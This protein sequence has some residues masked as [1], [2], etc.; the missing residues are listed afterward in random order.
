MIIQRNPRP[1]AT[2]RGSVTL[3]LAVLAPMLLILLGLIVAAGRIELAG[4]SVETA[5]ADA[6]R[7]ASIA[8]TPAAA[9]AAAEGSARATLAAEGLSCSQLSVAVDTAGFAAPLGQ[10]AAVSAHVSCTVTLADLLVPGMPGSHR[11]D[12]TSTSPLDPYRGRAL[13][14]GNSEALFGLNSSVGGAG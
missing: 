10:P 8:R 11:M 13:G 1:L 2:E 5:A 14:F 4:G 9:Q 3:E 7:Q 12:A 6:A